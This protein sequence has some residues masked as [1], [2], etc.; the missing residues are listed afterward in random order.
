VGQGRAVETEAN[1]LVYRDITQAERQLAPAR[2]GSVQLR[3][4]LAGPTVRASSQRALCDYT[5]CA[6]CN[7]IIKRAACDQATR[8]RS[9]GALPHRIGF[10]LL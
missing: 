5:Q 2:A 1:G 8:N 3:T 7:R 10:Y 9:V 4:V 6:Q